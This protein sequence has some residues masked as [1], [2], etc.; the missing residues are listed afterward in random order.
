MQEWW[1][2]KLMIIDFHSHLGDILSPNGGKLIFQTGIEPVSED[3]ISGAEENLY[4][5]PQD[6]QATT[7]AAAASAMMDLVTEAARSRNCSATLENWQRSLDEADIQMAVCLPIPPYLTFEDLKRA[8]ELD[9]R[10]IPF[11]GV[12]FTRQHNIELSLQQDVNQGAKGI[13]LHPIIQNLPLH[14]IRIHEAVEAFAPHNLPILLHCGTMSYYLGEEKE[15][16][17]TPAYGEVRYTQKLVSDFPT[18]SFV[19]G[20]AGL[21]EV[22]EVMERLG[23]FKNVWADISFQSPENVTELISIFGPDRVLFG[24]DWPFG[25]RPPMKTIVREVCRGDRSLEKMIFWENAVR[26]LRIKV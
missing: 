14:D 11:S 20:H 18:V 5:T 4:R 26:L 15:T 12:D 13:K 8:R 10:I 6:S 7:D 17:Q 24:S 9:A 21:F 1:K 22:Q 25:N 16:R 19:I 3:L 23:E 2:G